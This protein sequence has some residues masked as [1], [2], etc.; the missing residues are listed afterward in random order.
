MPIIQ[1]IEVCVA[2]VPLN[3]VTYLSNR[4]VVDRHYGLVKLRSTDGVE[5]IGPT[6]G[7]TVDGVLDGALPPFAGSAAGH[8]RCQRA[9]RTT[10]RAGQRAQ[11]IDR[12]VFR[13]VFCYFHRSRAAGLG[14][15]LKDR[16]GDKESGRLPEGR[17]PVLNGG[18]Y[19]A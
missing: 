9:A 16:G 5:G 10:R 3:K 2:R 8:R 11:C 7:R 12:S 18:A 15:A 6:L 17:R 14:P 19:R 1:S 13:R 4:T